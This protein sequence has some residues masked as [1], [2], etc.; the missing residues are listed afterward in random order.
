MNFV[1]DKK[2]TNLVVKSRDDLIKDIREHLNEKKYLIVLDDVWEKDLWGAVELAL[3]A[4]SNGIIIITTRDT[5][6]ADSCKDSAKVLMYPLNPLEHEDAL[7]LFYSKAFQSG[8]KS[9]SEELMKL[10]Q[11]FT[12][13]CEGVPLA[14]VAIASLLST[15]KETVSEWQL[16]YSSL[17]SKLAS[18]SRL[19][20]YY[21]VL[22]ESYQALSYH[23]KSCLLYFGLFPEQYAIKRSRLINLWIA[24]GF[25]ELRENQTQREVGEEY[26]AE[27]IARSLV[28][29]LRKRGYFSI[30]SKFL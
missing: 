28:K 3:P 5:G 26:L 17:Q 27:L 14:I 20:G 8:S 21:Q 30:Q 6:V 24:E 15:K 4:K 25:V 19:K 10:S 22:S 18:D 11:E 23:L 12:N 13:K 16:V 7:R 9:P 1:D 2:S 29:V